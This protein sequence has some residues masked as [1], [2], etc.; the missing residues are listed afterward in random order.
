MA[1]LETFTKEKKEQARNDLRALYDPASM[2][3]SDGYYL[4]SLEMRYGMSISELEK[5]SW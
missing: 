1:S 2:C 3:Y 4:K 5:N